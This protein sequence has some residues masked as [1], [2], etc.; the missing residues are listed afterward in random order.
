MAAY[1]CTLTSMPPDPV[2]MADECSQMGMEVV[3]EAPALC[4]EHCSPDHAVT[5]DTGF[6]HVP[7]L[8]LPPSTSNPAGY[9][10]RRTRHWQDSGWWI[11]TSLPHACVTAAF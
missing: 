8:A 6:A 4:A 2:E 9:R 1:A 7:P 3:Q 11:A 10:H 5:P